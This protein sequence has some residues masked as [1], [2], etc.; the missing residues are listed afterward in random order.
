MNQQLQKLT[1]V[2]QKQILK[3]ER[4]HNPVAWS[5]YFARRKHLAA[6][7]RNKDHGYNEVWMKHGTGSTD[8]MKL[9]ECEVGLDFRYCQSGYFGRAAYTAE[10]TCYSDNGYQYNNGDGTSSMILCRVAAGTIWDRR[11]EAGV[12]QSLTNPPP[13]YDSIRG[14]VDTAQGH[15]AIMVYSMD[16]AYPAYLVTY[17][18]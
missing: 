16:Q 8:P 18:S 15:Y 9:C 6:I 14:D 2:W 1:G 13:G 5:A 12:T 10:N 7:D 4:V 3:V 17:K 11:Y